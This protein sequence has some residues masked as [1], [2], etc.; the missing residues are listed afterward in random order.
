M[1]QSVVMESLNVEG[2]GRAFSLPSL[3]TSDC[4]SDMCVLRFASNIRRSVPMHNRNPC[5]V[6][7]APG[8]LGG[9]PNHQKK[10]GAFYT[11]KADGL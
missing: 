7:A 9:V 2:G 10:Y 11:V 4:Q 1:E 8:R 3:H 6:L 5:S